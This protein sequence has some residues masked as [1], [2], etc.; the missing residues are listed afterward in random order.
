MKWMR[1]A[2]TYA[3]LPVLP[4]LLVIVGGSPAQAAGYDKTYTN[5]YGYVFKCHSDSRWFD[6]PNK[7][8]VKIH[9]EMCLGRKGNTLAIDVNI[10]QGS[11]F[12]PWVG[13]YHLWDGL[14]AT[15]HL[16]RRWNGASVDHVVK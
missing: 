1:R 10:D 7:S 16:E 13:S 4:A 9:Y 5:E 2:L 14:Q 15:F 8:D 12:F 6:L 11:P 3:L